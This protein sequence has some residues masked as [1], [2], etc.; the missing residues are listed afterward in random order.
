MIYCADE[1]EA[2]ANYPLVSANTNISPLVDND[3]S[4]SSSSLVTDAESAFSLVENPNST[5]PLVADTDSAFPLVAGV[6]KW[7][8]ADIPTWQEGTEEEDWD[9][10]LME[11]GKTVVSKRQHIDIM[12]IDCHF[13]QVDPLVLSEM[14]RGISRLR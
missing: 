13:D 8:I 11:E 6:Q 3:N 2:C 9:A 10:E 1:E 5:A 7:S 12:C 14:F 4:T